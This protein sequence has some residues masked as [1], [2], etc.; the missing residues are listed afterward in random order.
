MTR[1][2][3][4]NQVALSEINKIVPEVLRRYDIEMAHD[5]PWSTFVALF[6]TQWNVVCN[7][8]RRNIV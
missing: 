1:L 8:K 2:T 4:H 5:Q 3:K 6:V 7:I